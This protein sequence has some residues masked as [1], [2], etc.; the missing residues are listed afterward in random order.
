MYP[1]RILVILGKLLRRV[2]LQCIHLITEFKDCHLCRRPLLHLLTFR[3][4][5]MSSVRFQT[6][7]QKWA[8]A[9]DKLTHGHAH[10][11]IDRQA[12]R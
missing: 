12:Y 11:Q 4:S 3:A 6:D 9:V 2:N 10:T 8:S 1:I 5:L 7:N